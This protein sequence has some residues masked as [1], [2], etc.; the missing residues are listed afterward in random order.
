MTESTVKTSTEN[1]VDLVEAPIRVLNVD[2]DSGF[3]KITKQILE[4]RGAFQVDTAS[5]VDE[6]VQVLHDFVQAEI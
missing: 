1:H 5:S 6:E 4:V 2:D 3:L